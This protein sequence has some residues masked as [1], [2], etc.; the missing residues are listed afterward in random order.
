V[1]S[2]VIS[3]RHRLY[4]FQSRSVVAQQTFACFR[5]VNTALAGVYAY[6]IDGSV[7]ELR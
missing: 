5:L 6:V 1:E 3:P 2:I 7:L 4:T